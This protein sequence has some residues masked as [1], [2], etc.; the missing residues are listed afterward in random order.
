MTNSDYIIYVDESGDHSL[1]SIDP[2]YPIFVVAFTI[3]HKATYATAVENLLHLKFET[4]GHDMIE[5][6][7]M[8]AKGPGNPE[9]R[10]RPRDPIH[11][12]K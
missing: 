9:A 5:G 11:L 10:R 1:T 7:S 3:F 12:S 2:H 6:V 4:F 8:K